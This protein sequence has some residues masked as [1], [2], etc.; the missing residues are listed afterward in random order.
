M[1]IEAKSPDEYI[2]NSRYAKKL[3]IRD[4]IFNFFRKFRLFDIFVKDMR[5]NFAY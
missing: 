5:S 4:D 2:N 1:R 3:G